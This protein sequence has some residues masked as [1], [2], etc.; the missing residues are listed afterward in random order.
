MSRWL[1]RFAIKE[2]EVFIFDDVERIDEKLLPD[3]FA[4][5]NQYVELIMRKCYWSAKTRKWIV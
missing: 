4:V 1:E 3:V 5:F 2:N